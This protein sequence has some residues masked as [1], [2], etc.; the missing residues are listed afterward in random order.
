MVDFQE[1]DSDHGNR[2]VEMT[3]KKL[4][5]MKEEV[6]MPYGFKIFEQ[7]VGLELTTL[8]AKV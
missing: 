6:D 1:V 3:I 5:E 2:I 4:L 7:I 8:I